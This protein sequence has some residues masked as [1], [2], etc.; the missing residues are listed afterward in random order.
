M[1]S[2]AGLAP[3]IITETLYH[4]TQTRKP[5]AQVSEIW[6]I[7]TAAGKQKVERELLHSRN[8]RFFQF[9]REYDIDAKK[10][11]FDREQIMVVPDK[12]GQPLSDI[13]TPEDNAALADF[14]TAFVREKVLNP[15]V[16]LHCSVAGG[17]KTMG[18]YLGLALQLYGRPNDTLSHVL[19]SPP[20]L[21]SDPAFYYP[22]RQSKWIM[23]KGQKLR[24]SQVRVELAEIPILKLR[25]KLPA[26]DTGEL[27]YSDLVK[28][29]Q[30][31]Y[32]LLNA[33]PGAVVDARAL[34]V[35]VDGRRIRLS[36][37]ETAVY[38]IF[39][40]ARRTS[41]G[42]AGCPG[43]TKCTLAASDFLGVEGISRVRQ[44]LQSLKTKDVRLQELRGW[45]AKDPTDPEKR[46]REVR[47]RLNQKIQRTLGGEAWPALYTIAALRLP[48]TDRVRY[49]IRL[50]PQLLTIR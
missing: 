36:P 32:A 8:G 5:T 13:R 34:S 6:V 37:L 21:E 23:V 18:L 27:P 10:I 28:R 4:L 20:V 1:I 45:G 2:V 3:Q 16:S 42:K 22:P 38:G 49:G 9:C 26:L 29:A 19:V 17:R 11:I 14:V 44:V 7:T 30:Q 48:G 12:N 47:S 43:C 24:A 40:K 15:D 31:D 35:L 25:G 46:F 33:P 39:A 41:C 50:D